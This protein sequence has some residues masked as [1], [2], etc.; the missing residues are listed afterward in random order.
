MVYGKYQ[1]DG[2]GELLGKIS[3]ARHAENAG[4]VSDRDEKIG[5]KKEE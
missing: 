2:D 3:L 4:L 1:G 5:R